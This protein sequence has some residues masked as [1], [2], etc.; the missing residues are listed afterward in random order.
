MLQGALYVADPGDPAERDE[1]Y[2]A[3]FMWLALAILQ[4]GTNVKG[5]LYVADPGYPAE[6]D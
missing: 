5:A 3:S 4:N 2:K 6:R 1:C